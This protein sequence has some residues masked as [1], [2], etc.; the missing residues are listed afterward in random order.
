MNGTTE[1]RPI[2]KMGRAEAR[3]ATLRARAHLRTGWRIILDIYEREGWRALGYSSWREYAAVEFQVSR[4]AAYRLLDCARVV[5]SLLQH[6]VD[7][8]DMPKY[9]SHLTQLAR[10]PTGE[11]RA[12]IWREA[13]EDGDPT[14]AELAELVDHYREDSR[15]AP[16]DALPDLRIYP[17]QA[18]QVT[19]QRRSGTDWAHRIVRH[20]EAFEHLWDKPDAR[21]AAARASH[22]KTMAILMGRMDA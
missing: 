4:S 13:A 12:A 18:H 20:M 14:D 5:E 2:A 22:E 6:A 9:E 3:E 11:L 7:I 19:G 8:I 15:P 16:G 1:T 17:P 10:V 21:I